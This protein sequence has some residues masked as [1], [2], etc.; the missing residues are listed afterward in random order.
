[1]P[2]TAKKKQKRVGSPGRKKIVAAVANETGAD[3]LSLLATA[4]D[5]SGFWRH[6]ENMRRI[7][8]VPRAQFQILIKPDLVLFD[9]KASTG[10][11]PELVEHLIDLL[12]ARRFKAVA[13]CG[14]T[15]SS[16]LWLENRDVM[17]LAELVGYRYATPT[18]HVY[19]V[20]D[21]GGD[22][23]ESVFPADSVLRDEGI[24][25]RWLD[26][27]FRISFAKNKTDQENGFALNTQNL[28]GV[29]PR[30]NKSFHYRHRLNAPDVSLALLRRAP[31][32]FSIIDA[33][34][35]NHGS[36]GTCVSRP[37]KTGTII[38]SADMLLADWTA[39]L[40]M[41]LDPFASPINA[42][43]L[44]EIGLPKGHEIVG[45]LSAY[46]GWINVAPSL[47]DSVRK[48]NE[49]AAVCRLVEPWLHS[50]NRELFPFKDAV[51]DR[52]N[53]VTQKMFGDLDSNAMAASAMLALNY[54]LAMASDSLEAFHILYKKSALKR[55]E[56]S[57]D[58]DP[59]SFTSDEYRAVI[60]YM[61][62]L[63][64]IIR[65]APSEPSGLR[66]R[67]IDG[68]VLFQFSQLIDA[69]WTKFAARV[70]ISK[71]VQSMNDY[72]GGACVP[73]SRDRA[74][75]V[76]QQAERNIYLPQPNWMA[77]FGGKMI[78]VGKIEFIR[79]ERDRHRIFWRMIKSSNDSAQFDDGIVTFA[80]EKKQTRVTIIG[81]Q[82]FTLPLIWQLGNI[83]LAP[84]IKDPLV[85][86]AY[87]N[88]FN[89]TI[90]NFISQYQGREYHA[91]QAWQVDGS[92]EDV[93]G[94]QGIL[95]AFGL[96]DTRLEKCFTGFARLVPSKDAA[97]GLVDSHVEDENGFRHFPG[98]LAN[99]G[100]P[101]RAPFSSTVDEARGFFSDLAEAMRKDLGVATE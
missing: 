64:R 66:W 19:E 26:G 90:S 51:N 47:M 71:A 100:L 93:P 10:T 37:L 53:A 41:G 48:R 34:V 74:G 50:V 55:Y 86:Q 16:D 1:M 81:R 24:S 43:A 84:R 91:G 13:V 38:A 28:L 61:E 89:G 79:Y 45:D 21:L 73:V 80:R 63:E 39:S 59:A 31:A 27:H 95:R 44:R 88:Y 15:D 101:S 99:N 92:D 9:E 49:S 54:F 57:L 11:D 69:P 58:F 32:H 46:E 17:V 8:K 97:I 42:K 18:G 14:A 96:G 98:N 40:K 75:R 68:S 36:A 2:R 83:D 62:P 30:R 85:V 60:D 3:K 56:T 65:A 22:L 72:I 87:T 25:R 12:R 29:L 78:D 33:F 6:L 94:L 82:K 5:Q 4:L 70:D 20:I 7:V 67:Y 23:V 76:I 52:I 77:L 35:S